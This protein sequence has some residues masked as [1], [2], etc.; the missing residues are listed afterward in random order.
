M[1]DHF[2]WTS[3][4][5]SVH[6]EKNRRGGIGYKNARFKKT[7]FDCFFFPPTSIFNM[8]NTNQVLFIV[9]IAIIFSL[10]LLGVFILMNKANNR[11]RQLFDLE[12]RLQAQ[13]QFH[14]QLMAKQ[15][16]SNNYIDMYQPAMVKQG[17]QIIQPLVI[18][19]PQKKSTKRESLLNKVYGFRNVSSSPPYFPPTSTTTTMRPSA[20]RPP[21][22]LPMQEKPRA[23]PPPAYDDYDTSTLLS[24]TA[25]DTTTK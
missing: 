3:K 12:Q 18:M 4:N 16:Q 24:Y 1:S 25:L 2:I 23:S 11:R 5:D 7:L 19:T 17:H 22:F 13:E 9:I 15:Q 6:N 10:T 21:S 14:I 20:I 8:P